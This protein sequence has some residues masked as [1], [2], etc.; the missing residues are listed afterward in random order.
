MKTTEF[1]HDKI[2]NSANMF[3]HKSGI[4]F[5]KFLST[6]LCVVT[7]TKKAFTDAGNQNA[8]RQ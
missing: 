6:L 7:E 8:S 1:D 5:F 4:F 2:E 3:C